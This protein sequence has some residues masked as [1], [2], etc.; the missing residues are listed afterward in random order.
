MTRVARLYQDALWLGESE[1]NLS[2]L[3]LVAAVETAANSWS[4]GENSP[5]ERM[6]EARPELMAY[7]QSTA[8]ADVAVRIAE[9]FANSVGSTK[10]FVEFLIQHVPDAP[11]VRPGEWGQIDWSAE[12]LRRAFRQIYGYRSRALH[13]GMPFPAPMCD[14]PYRHETWSCVAEKPIGLA[15]SIAGGTWLAKDTPML[16]HTFEYI[17]RNAL[18]KWW[19]TIVPAS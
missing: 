13:D 12:G 1:P 10:K 9:E 4:I 18:M 17:A 16:L 19:T 15:A 14:P 2:W 8:G 11:E 5:I 6:N 7:L 3:L